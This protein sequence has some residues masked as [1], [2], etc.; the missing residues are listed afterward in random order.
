M[1]KGTHLK[2]NKFYFINNS[3]KQYLFIYKK[4]KSQICRLK[5]NKTLFIKSF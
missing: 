1:K 3:N 5:P 2:F 4:F